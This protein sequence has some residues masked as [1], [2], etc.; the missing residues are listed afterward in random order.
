M[1][2]TASIKKT[3]IGVG[4]ISA[5][6]C[7]LILHALKHLSAADAAVGA[8]YKQRYG[9]YLLANKLRQG[10]DDLTRAARLYVETGNVRYEQMYQDIIDIRDGR[11][12]RPLH[13]E[14]IYWNFIEAGEGKPVADGNRASIFDLMRKAGFTE[15]EFSKLAEAKRRSDDLTRTEYV[16]MNAAKGWFDDGSGRFGRRGLPDRELALR[17]LTDD[18]YQKN[19][20]DIMR[21]V[22]EL[23]VMVDM[24]TAGVVAQAE[25]K[26]TDATRI[27]VALQFMSLAVILF[28]IYCAYR[29]LV[30]KIESERMIRQML[31]SSPVSVRVVSLASGRVLFANDA[32]LQMLDTDASTLLGSGGDA[33]YRDQGQYA[34]ISIRL[35]RGESIINE[36]VALLGKNG[37]VIRALGS[38]LRISYEGESAALNWCV[39]VTELRD[40]KEAA[41]AAARAKGEFL[42]NMSHEIRTPMN[43]IIGMSHLALQTQLDT[44]QRNYVEKVHRAAQGLLGVINDILDFSKIEAGKLTIE[45][46]PFRLEQV[47]DSFAGVIGLKAEEQ[48]LELLFDVGPDVP[49]GLI[50]DRL[51]LEQVVLNLGANAVKFTNSGEVLVSVDLED[52]TDAGVELHFRVKDTG[53]GMTPEQQASL[54]DSF[55]QADASTTRRYGGTGLG[56]VISRRL[57]ELM[58]GRIWV[59][60]EYGRGT[61]MH[62]TVRLGAQQ[63]A[64]N[65]RQRMDGELRGLRVLIADDN[66]VAREILTTMAVHIG[67]EVETA[68]DGIVVPA[69]VCDAEEAG[70]PYDLLLLDWKMPGQDGIQ[71]MRRL[72]QQRAVS[73]PA[74]IMVTAF[75]RG[76]VQQAAERERVHPSAVLTKPVTRSSLLDAVGAAPGTGMLA[77]SRAGTRAEQDAGVMKALSGARVLLVE[78]NELNQELAIELLRSVGV[79]VVVVDDGQQALDFLAVDHDFDG[80]L[81]DCQMP[82][83]DGYAAMRV[84]RSTPAL[85]SIPVIAMTANAMTGDR[86][87]SIKAGMVDHIAKP[88]RITEMFSTLERWVKP[89][90][91]RRG[92]V[93]I[94]MPAQ[95]RLSTLPA[96]PGVDIEAA[97]EM[98]N[99]DEAL[100]RKLLL[101]FRDG[102]EHFLSRF[103]EAHRAGNRLTAERLVHTLKGTAAQIGAAQLRDAASQLEA[104]CRD[105]ANAQRI[106]EAV[107][108]VSATLHPL[109]AGLRMLE[110]QETA[111]PKP[112]EA[113][114]PQQTLAWNVQFV[115]LRALVDASDTA[116]CDLVKELLDN[117]MNEECARLLS[118]VVRRLEYF[119]FDDA[120]TLLADT[121]WQKLQRMEMKK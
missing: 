113:A 98:T 74:V 56:L 82:V 35:E 67:L 33:I 29:F 53:I 2:K 8:A 80:I 37:R 61:T 65:G 15:Q 16:A 79:D 76:E 117:A 97:L 51:R 101:K 68:Q 9:S 21:P 88:V 120:A 25:R 92:P 60:S 115:R 90:A 103:S 87:K 49:V 55:T 83:M 24:R 63:D 4:L 31:E 121:Q 10:S 106:G 34:D 86:E 110:T 20:A 118:R 36:P 107:E 57:V 69:M 66:A 102:Q 7:L 1:K 50:G 95:P 6:I 5:A 77:G 3:A 104:L 99:G 78:D 47:L 108:C 91:S 38:V 96:L 27:V 18:S 109:L 119:E 64:S 112:W 81:M 30:R 100:Y 11:K 22:N 89:A 17:L 70:R 52:K 14:R 105:G 42:A 19:K 85:A 45:H 58:G 71:T 111:D 28:S 84:I 75:G 93:S 73:Q 116:A 43:A 46:A 62:F 41:E 72:A 23:L 13:S 26:S 32:C 39:D 48:G 94:T 12:P 54:F 44:Q 59:E 40:A 114:W